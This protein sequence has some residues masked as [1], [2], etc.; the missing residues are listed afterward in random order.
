MQKEEGREKNN[1][2]QERETW[3]EKQK[4]RGETKRWTAEMVSWRNSLGQ[5]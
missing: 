4:K 2:E 5:G 1:E 3:K